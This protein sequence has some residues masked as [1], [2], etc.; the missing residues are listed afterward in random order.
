MSHAIGDLVLSKVSN[1]DQHYVN[2]TIT[3]P[4]SLGVA[5]PSPLYNGVHYL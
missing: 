4:L 2:I 3:M 5:L 1:V